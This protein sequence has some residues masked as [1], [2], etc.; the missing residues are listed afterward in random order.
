MKQWTYQL[1]LQ[2]VASGESD[3]EDLVAFEKS[4]SHHLVRL[5]YVDGH[6]FGC[7]EF[8]LFLLTDDPLKTSEISELLRRSQLPGYVP[9]IAYR[10]MLG[11]K[12]IVLSPAGYTDFRIA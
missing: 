5:A 11:E 12:Y 3:F 2:F 1:V 7:G 8:N 9:V 4:L 10:E 6:D